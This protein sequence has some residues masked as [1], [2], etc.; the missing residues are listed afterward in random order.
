MSFQKRLTS[1]EFVVVA[2]MNT[3]KGVDI[4]QLVT[5]ARRIKGRVDAVVIPD[6]D[7]GVMRMSAL[8]GGVI[9]HQQGI[10]SIIHVYCRDRN[11]MAL[12]GDLLAAHVL[13]IQNLI[14]VNGEEMTNGDHRE[15]KSVD[16]LNEVELLEA[17]GSLQNGQDMA[18]FELSGAPS[19]TIGCSIAS[20][21]DDNE[22]KTELELAAK[23][24][25]AGAQYIVTPP[26]FD[27]VHFEKFIGAAKGLNV[28]II[29]SIFLIKSVGIARY[30]ALNEPGSHI[31]EELI[32]RI[33]KASDRETECLRIAGETIAALK[34]KVAGVKIETLG[35]EHRLPAILDYAG[36]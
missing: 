8:A 29:A 36:L 4:T 1:D 10:E 34:D 17:I 14:V 9:M 23:K 26:V 13:G 2:E 7:N 28:P 24:V 22:M 25:A 20:F 33:R 30:M 35:W 27:V 18:G 21:S 32:R 3:P 16:D 11:R 12:Q 6:M 19:F 15:A 31:S 5:N